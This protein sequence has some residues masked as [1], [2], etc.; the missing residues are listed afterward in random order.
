MKKRMMSGLIL[1][2]MLIGFSRTISAQTLTF[3]EG[4][5]DNGSAISPAEVFNIN[6][7]G[8]YLYFLVNMSEPVNCSYVTYKLY[9]VNSYGNE[10]FSTSITQDGMSDNW[11]WFYKKVTFYT[12]GSYK[13]YVRDCNSNLIATG[14]VEIKIN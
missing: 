7:D 11:S 8:G 12:A 4:V 14:Y 5:S 10:E 9:T 2:I 3:C 13:V 6:S 1:F